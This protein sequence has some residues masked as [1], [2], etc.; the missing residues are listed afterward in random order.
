MAGREPGA[1]GARVYVQRAVALCRQVQGDRLLAGDLQ[2]GQVACRHARILAGV[3]VG[4][5]ATHALAI[6]RVQ[7]ETLELDDAV[8]QRVL[9]QLQCLE[10]P[11]EGRTLR[12]Q[13][14]GVGLVPRILAMQV[15]W[16]QE[17]ALT[18]EHL[19]QSVHCHD[20]S[21]RSPMRDAP[22]FTTVRR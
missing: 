8:A 18:P 7:G 13:G 11:V 22:A 17:A 15:L 3:G 20:L 12:M 6:A 10:A 4:H 9:A 1:R 5:A 19:T 16:R 2:V 21:I 14:Q